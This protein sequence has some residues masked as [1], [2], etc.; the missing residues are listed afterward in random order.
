MKETFS[1]IR[2]IKADHFS[3]YLA[4]YGR[5]HTANCKWF[6][7]RCNDFYRDTHR[8]EGHL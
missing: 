3:Q 5:L 4:D 1:R 6:S 8:L 7:D 2:F